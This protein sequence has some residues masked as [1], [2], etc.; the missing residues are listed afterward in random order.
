MITL[1]TTHNRTLTQWQTNLTQ[2][3]R[4]F[5]RLWVKALND[6][7]DIAHK[8]YDRQFA[9][10]GAEF[11]S[12]WKALAARTQI[13]RVRHGYRPSRPIL[14]RRGW[15]RAS[16]ASK[17]SA[18]AQRSVNM[19]GITMWS[20]VP[21]RGHNLLDI[22]QHGTNRIPARPIYREGTPP[23]ISQRGW[24]EIQARLT[25]MFVELRRMVE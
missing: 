13:D 21:A 23:Y 15:L 1:G 20:S 14:V 24:N 2:M 4:A 18:H 9:N 12:P 11:G 16:V 10:Q 25:G 7:G 5:P 17:S 8:Y 3:R 19:Q 22:H 6:S